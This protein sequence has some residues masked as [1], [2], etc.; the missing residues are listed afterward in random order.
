MIK[1]NLLCLTTKA[2]TSET[3]T[4]SKK[5]L[6]AGLSQSFAEP[7]TSQTA[8]KLQLRFSTSKY[9]PKCDRNTLEGDDEIQL[10]SEI[11]ILS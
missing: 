4:Y 7:S 11:D 2:K 5:S 3:S 9:T 1:I 10:Q 8:R 6:A